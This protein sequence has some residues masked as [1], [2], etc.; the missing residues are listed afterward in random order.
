[1]TKRHACCTPWYRP[2]YFCRKKKNPDRFKKTWK[3]LKLKKKKSH[4][5]LRFGGQVEKTHFVSEIW[6]FDS[7][8]FSLSIY[9]KDCPPPPFYD[10]IPCIHEKKK[11]KKKKLEVLGP[12][13]GSI[14]TEKFWFSIMQHEMSG[15]DRQKH[16]AGIRTLLWVVLKKKKKKKEDDDYFDQKFLLLKELK[17][18]W[19]GERSFPLPTIENQ[20]NTLKT[21]SQKGVRCSQKHTYTPAFTLEGNSFLPVLCPTCLWLH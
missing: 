7:H 17:M 18:R 9:V 6:R 20:N 19:W 11:G 5:F 13:V 16:Q 4:I 2:P 12:H 1:M 21:R 8:A 14:A 3:E 10:A 15:F